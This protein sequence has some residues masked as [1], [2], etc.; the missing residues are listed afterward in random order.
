MDRA[1]EIIKEQDKLAHALLEK[2]YENSYAA[3]IKFQEELTGHIVK[4]AG[5]SLEASA[6]ARLGDIHRDLQKKEAAKEAYVAALSHKK[7]LPFAKGWAALQLGYIYLKQEEYNKAENYFK[8]S[9]Y[10]V[11]DRYPYHLYMGW[12]AAWHGLQVP[13][14]AMKCWEFIIARAEVDS[15]K[16]FEE[17]S[18]RD[19]IEAALNFLNKYKARALF[20]AS[21]TLESSGNYDRAAKCLTASQRISP[22]LSPQEFKSRLSKLQG[23]SGS[24]EQLSL[25]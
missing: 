6:Q 11:R 17:Q 7:A 8:A 25:Q 24:G 22:K 4:Y 18:D 16:I 1:G 12:G 13:R 10:L 19:R 21:C 5:T 3:R 20:N 2:S 14:N 15:K 9:C 23:L